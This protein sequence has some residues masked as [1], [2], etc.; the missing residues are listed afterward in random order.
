LCAVA[1]L[2]ALGLGL[3]RGV[4]SPTPPEPAVAA[5]QAPGDVASDHDLFITQERAHSLSG[6]PGVAFVDCRSEAEFA[7]GHVSGSLHVEPG[8]ASTGPLVQALAGASTVIT[9]CDADQ[10]CER[11][12]RVASMLQRAGVRDVRVLEGGMPA[13]LA[14]GYPAESGECGQCEVSP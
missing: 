11:S 12:L 8:T 4:P 10:Q 13:W 6:S 3:V 14:R 1:L 2:L 7:A 9:Y 5:C